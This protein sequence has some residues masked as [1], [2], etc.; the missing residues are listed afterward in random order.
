MLNRED[1][2]KAL[3]NIQ[4]DEGFN[5]RF[6]D[7]SEEFTI[8]VRCRNI[9][10]TTCISIGGYG[11]GILTFDLNKSEDYELIVSEIIANYDI[12]KLIRFEKGNY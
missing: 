7:D 3:R 4:I 9:M 11:T 5:I 8:G 10:D 6:K 2:V 1:L 12:D